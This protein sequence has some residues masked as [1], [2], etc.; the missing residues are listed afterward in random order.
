M[1]PKETNGEYWVIPPFH[2]PV[3]QF[4]DCLVV[5]VVNL[6]VIYRYDLREEGSQGTAVGFF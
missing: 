4:N 3:S 1:D 6:L 2:L 5:R